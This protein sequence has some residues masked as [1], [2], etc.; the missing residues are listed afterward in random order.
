M[1]GSTSGDW[2]GVS[3]SGGQRR[4][5][6]Q[7]TSGTVQ[8]TG[9]GGMKGTREKCWSS[10]GQGR[11]NIYVGQVLVKNVKKKT[12]SGYVGQVLVKGAVGQVLVTK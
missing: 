1:C 4:T 10:V 11:G 9:K 2:P 7:T 12:F 5:R 8:T 6:G 3:A